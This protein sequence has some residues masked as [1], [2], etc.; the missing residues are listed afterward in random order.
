MPIRQMVKICYNQDM[1]VKKLEPIQIDNFFTQKE[2]D[3]VY[4]NVYQKMEKGLKEKKDKYAEMFKFLN[5]GFMTIYQGWPVELLDV[6]RN[7][8]EELGLGYV[9]HKNTALIFARY[10]HDSGGMPSLTPHVDVV[11][12]K[13]IYTC[14]VRLKSTK[15]WDF[16]VKDEKFLMPNQGSAVW[17]T[18]NQD[19]HWRPDIYFGP[20]DY[21]DI[22]LCQ[23]WSDV[24]NEEYPPDHKEKMILQE[25]EYSEKYYHML[26]ESFAA[27]VIDDY[28]TD[29][30][31]VSD[32]QTQDEAYEAAYYR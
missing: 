10:S 2:F 32:G 12:N 9:P 7:K 8:A 23:V 30:I 13:T 31:G 24:G 5:Q 4:T 15:Q 25:K 28:N 26:K 27:K 11:A 20:D 14:T 16:Y 6:I 19:A 21:Y 18:G 22:L 1:S 29:C 3:L 17:F